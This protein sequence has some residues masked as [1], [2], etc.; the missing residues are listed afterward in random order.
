MLGQAYAGAGRREEAQKIIR[1]L[2]DRATQSYLSP[3]LVASIYAR[4]GDKD[5]TIVRLER[6]YNNR[7]DVLIWIK[8]DPKLDV[9]RSDPRFVDLLRRVGFSQ[10]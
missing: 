4:L 10:S 1:D 8:V 9:V 3:Y 7:D 6:A 2:D 5:Q